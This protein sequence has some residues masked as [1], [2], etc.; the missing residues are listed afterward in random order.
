MQFYIFDN[1]VLVL[2]SYNVQHIMRFVARKTS[3][4]LPQVIKNI[5]PV[6]TV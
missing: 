4:C 2:L 3:Y 1:I 6:T 5:I